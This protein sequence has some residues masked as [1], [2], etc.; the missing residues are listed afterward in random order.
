MPTINFFDHIA[1]SDPMREAAERFNAI[2]R[3]R[4]NEQITALMDKAS[5]QLICDYADKRDV[6]NFGELLALQPA[7]INSTNVDNDTPLIC[8]VESGH[9][10]IF[11]LCLA[12]TQL[13]INLRGEEGMTAGILA[14]ERNF[15]DFALK[16]TAREDL[17]ITIQDYDGDTMLIC[18]VENENPEIVKAI[19]AREGAD[20]EQKNNEEQS[21]RSIAESYKGTT[22]DQRAV[23]ELIKAH[24]SYSITPT[25]AT[26]EVSAR[27][28]RGDDPQFH[29]IKAPILRQHANSYP[30]P[31]SVAFLRWADAQGFKELRHASNKIQFDSK[32]LRTPAIRTFVIDKDAMY[33]DNPTRNAYS[34]IALA[35]CQHIGYDPSTDY[36]LLGG[37][38]PATSSLTPPDPK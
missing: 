27:R 33:A 3:E 26:R 37:S 4:T 19:L 6:K 11:D 16:L 1:P 17:D 13:K 30:F 36:P 38:G 21:A 2:L 18:A 15:T 12:E 34:P 28:S 5:G 14:C 29:D 35:I 7:L 23:L 32:G 24:K 25:A 9:E 8:A 10:R 20:V 22:S 31:H